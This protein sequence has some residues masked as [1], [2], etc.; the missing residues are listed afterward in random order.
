M[1]DF[2]T[3][4]PNEILTVILSH[5][6]QNDCLR[7]MCVSRHWFN[8]IPKNMQ[9]A[10]NSVTFT[11]TSRHYFK[12]NTR[13]LHCLGLYT[14]KAHISL[15]DAE[16][17]CDILQVLGDMN[18]TINLIEI[19]NPEEEDYGYVDDENMLYQSLEQFSDSLTDLT[20][21][22]QP[23][24]ISPF[25][26]LSHLPALTHLTF[27]YQHT[28][29]E[30]LQRTQQ[31]YADGM[32]EFVS[33]VMFL[34]LDSALR[35][36]RRIMALLPHCPQLKALIVTTQYES[37]YGSDLTDGDFE[38]ILELCPRVQ[39]VIWFCKNDS[40][41]A[42][43]DKKFQ[44][45]KALAMDPEQRSQVGIREV[46]LDGLI[47]QLE[48]ALPLVAGSQQTLEH[49]LICNFD[50]DEGR[51]LP[52]LG[53]MRFPKMKKLE[54]FDVELTST[55]W[56]NLV[57]S[58]QT[59]EHLWIVNGQWPI[60]E[61]INP[62]IAAIGSLKYLQ[63]LELGID[64]Q[65]S[66]I[67]HQDLSRNFRSFSA[68]VS[69]RSLRLYTMCL[70]RQGLLGLCDIPSLQELNISVG[71]KHLHCLQLNEWVAFAE[72]LALVN[73]GLRSLILDGITKI[74]DEVLER[75]GRVKQL[76]NLTI[77]HAPGITNA[78]VGLFINSREKDPSMIKKLTIQDCHRV[79]GGESSLYGLKRIFTSL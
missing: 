25:H 36:D 60:Q 48:A 69:L 78:G 10:W 12:P 6:D 17:A 32:T 65:I 15:M 35:Y 73:D 56:A 22:D 45:W 37:Y 27:L 71:Y 3:F 66:N 31:D 5:L 62:M 11:H 8:A 41:R 33:N 77:H 43:D 58:C 14:Q 47:Y 38:S 23:S 4:L 74:T 2:T 51:V 21:L 64:L 59:L 53:S 39:F 52:G 40:Y 42:P 75:L 49:L 57:S 50:E 28:S 20:L 26:L 44:Q 34:N 9:A 76:S 16:E 1:P 61:N 19:T 55:G 54:V 72:R 18:C 63:T 29:I 79:V 7:C 24:D 13:L 30:R 70:S 67:G 46:E 68:S